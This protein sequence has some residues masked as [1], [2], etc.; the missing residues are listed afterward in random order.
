MNIDNN[1]QSYQFRNIIDTGY[2]YL[3]GFDIEVPKSLTLKTL[4]ELMVAKYRTDASISNEQMAMNIYTFCVS[5]LLSDKY[6]YQLKVTENGADLCF[7]DGNGG[8]FYL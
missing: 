8:N 7:F 4:V 5:S 2:K 6:A 1:V 3:N